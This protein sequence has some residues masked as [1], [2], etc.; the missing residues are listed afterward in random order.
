[1]KV[2]LV[3]A[4][5]VLGLL[6]GCARRD[7]GPAQPSS[8]ADG[9]RAP[10]QV[11]TIAIEQTS[12]PIEI[13]GT[14]QAVQRAQ[15]AARVTGTIEEM[16]LILGQRVHAGDK[17]VTIAAPDMAARLAMARTR[18]DAAR[19]DL[20]RERG[21]LTQGASAK[22]T[23]RE[24]EDRVKTSE[25]QLREAE[26]TLEFAVLRAPFDGVIARRFAN[27]GDLTTPG[28]PLLEVHGE[29]PFEI[30]AAVPESDAARIKLGDAIP[31]VVPATSA[32]LVARLT[33]IASA[34]DARARSVVI[35]LAVPPGAAVRGGQFARLQIP[36]EPRPMIRVPLSAVT[37]FGQMERVFT[38]AADN[39]AVLRLVKTG[40]RA[41]DGVEILSGLN[42]GD[43]VIVAPQPMLRDGQPVEVRP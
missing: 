14:V 31:V 32:T 12:T 34:A 42:V 5:T 20:E 8:A 41:N 40:A 43:R 33:E 25:A 18:L 39:R 4:V 26:A 29:N 11:V 10:V 35:K 16:P 21:L 9:V 3:T 38:V 24:L 19:K 22:E 28:T 1:M 36:G 23:V 15:I 27:R 6:A 7:A 17:L 2:Q 37:T 30:E 13:T